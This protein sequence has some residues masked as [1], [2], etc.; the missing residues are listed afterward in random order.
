MPRRKLPPVPRPP[1][2]P[3]FLRQLALRLKVTPARMAL[4]EKTARP[5][6]P[7]EH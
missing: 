7:V 3:L 6:R 5:S 1:R 4:L 2:L